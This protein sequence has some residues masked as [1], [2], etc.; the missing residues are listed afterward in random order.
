M[1]HKPIQID[2]S[3]VHRLIAAQFPKWK[4]LPVR[5]VAE[6]GWDNRMF[7]LGEQMLV[8]MPSGAEYADKVAKEQKWLPFLASKLPLP[9]PRPLALGKP[10]TDYPW[11]WSVYSY[12]EGESLAMATIHDL[13]QFALDLAKF[14]RALHNVDTTGGPPPGR[15]NRGGSPAAY[16]Q[17]TRKAI[18]TLDGKI[19]GA[20]ALRVWETGLASSWQNPPVWVHG[21]ISAGNLL[22]QNGK[23]SAVIDWGSLCIGDPACDLAIY[24]TFFR[25]PSRDKFRAVLSLDQNTWNR[26]RAW[27]LWK[28]LIVA[29][30]FS[31]PVNT[32]SKQCWRIIEDVLSQ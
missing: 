31:N 26:A 25:G 9:I 13:N 10:C 23:L 6:G 14:L 32:E 15:F 28:A 1:N 27:V 19:E 17:E 29:A 18:A 22:V 4:D 5:P 11:Q 21:D 7:H 8:R 3:L 16:D 20:H 2:T 12:L 30:G 24:W